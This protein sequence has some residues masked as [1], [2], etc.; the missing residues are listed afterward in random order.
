MRSPISRAHRPASFRLLRRVLLGIAVVVAATVLAAGCRQDRERVSTQ[1]VRLSDLRMM[2]VPR[3]GLGVLGI[4]L[5]VSGQS[6]WLPNGAAADDSID[7]KDTAGSLSR[8]GRLGGYG[9]TYHDPRGFASPDKARP[10]AVSTEVDLFRDE[11]AASAYLHRS[12]A[13]ILRLRGRKLPQGK[14][15]SAERFGGGDVG[16]E[17][18]GI[19]AALVVDDYVGYTSAVAFRR[20]RMV[21]FTSLTQRAEI[22]GPGEV[23]RIAGEL[24]ERISGVA[25]SAIDDVP[26]RLPPRKW[27]HAVPDPRPLAIEGREI[28]PGARRVHRAY[29]RTPVSLAYLREYELPGGRLGGSRILYARTMTQAFK[30]ARHAARDQRYLSSTRGSDA[31]ARRFLRAYFRKTG[32]RPSEISGRPLAAPDRDTAALRFSFDAPRSP[33]AGAMVSVRRGRL[34]GSVMV[35]ALERQLRPEDV[36]ALRERLRARLASA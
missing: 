5:N 13:D 23:L 19:R 28:S 1:Q 21:A 31:I 33:I 36:L 16:D 34:T 14:I 24:D 17:A 3:D 6:G 9:L 18:E 11:A 22:Q 4:G 2:V 35:L 15:A 7:P 30:T 10:F 32:F 26:V 29:F 8:R 27:W 25:T 20:G 12:V